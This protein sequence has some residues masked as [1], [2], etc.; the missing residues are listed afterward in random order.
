MPM[1]IP[2]NSPNSH[3]SGTGW[4]IA[5]IGCLVLFLLAGLG[6]VLLVRT[7]KERM[8]HPSK[9]D[10]MGIAVLA[11]QAGGDGARLRMAVVAY[12]AKHG[13]YPNTLVDLVQDGTVDGKL[14]HNDLDD[15]PS[16]GHVS[17]T[18]RK[19]AENAP[20]STPILEEPYQMTIGGQTQSSKIVISLNG[21]AQ[22][23]SAGSVPAQ[24]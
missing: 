18:Y 6:G 20:G 3:N 21:Q 4:K 7:L 11:G 23:P 17:W 15:H 2:N 24:P 12:H 1:S 19:P 8:D 22:T 9:K 14:L 5:G 10:I 13:H 16:P